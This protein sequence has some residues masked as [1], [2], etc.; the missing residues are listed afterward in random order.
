MERWLTRSVNNLGGYQRQISGV[1]MV[2]IRE[3]G[4]SVPVCSE[5]CTAVWPAV[6]C[7]LNNRTQGVQYQPQAWLIFYPRQNVPF[8]PWYFNQGSLYPGHGVTNTLWCKFCNKLFDISAC[9]VW[10]QPIWFGS[11]QPEKTGW[12]AEEKGTEGIWQQK[13]PNKE[14]VSELRA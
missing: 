11:S 10:L 3:A 13:C 7:T 9:H 12:I 1:L 6:G 8:L 14:A 5:F 4:Q 2:M